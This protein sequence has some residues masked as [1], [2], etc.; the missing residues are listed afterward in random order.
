MIQKVAN[1]EN[2][3]R[4]TTD[5]ESDGKSMSTR[6]YN[7]LSRQKEVFEPVVPGKVGIYCCGPTVYAPSHVGHVVGPVIFDTVKR[8][9]RYRGYD[10]TFVIN[11]TDVDDKIINK[12]AEEKTSTEELAERITADYIEHLGRLGVEVDHFPRATK[13]IPHM[14]A[15]IETLV[16]KGFAYPSGG[17]VYFDVTRHPAY[18]KLSNRNIDEMMAGARKEVSDLKRHPSDFA[19]WKGAKAG[20]PAWES[21]WGPGRPGWHIECSAMSMDLLG[22]TFDI[23]G[24]GLDLCFPHH[25]D[26]IAQSECC[27]GKTYAK[28]WMHNGLMQYG[29]D[30]RKMGG[31]CMAEEGDIASQEAAKMSKSKGNIVTLAKLLSDY[32]PELIRFFLLSTHYRSPISFSDERL[33]EVGALLEKAH[34]FAER[35][36]QV[37]G[38]AFYE[39]KAP[40]TWA[41]APFEAGGSEFLGR[42]VELRNRY[43]EFMDDDFN[44]AGAIGTMA[45]LITLLNRQAG[46]YES[47]KD[48]A[49]KTEFAAGAV[50]LKELADILGILTK[51]P[52]SAGGDDQLTASLLDLLLKVRQMARQEKSFALSDAIRDELAE[53]GVTIKDGKE[54][55]SWKIESSH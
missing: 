55:S 3:E 54:G 17:D 7:T 12:A 53:L 18:G 47:S 33:K 45:E 42:V 19:L 25:E 37:M 50:V 20:E 5:T 39:L 40:Q 49:T 2:A 23:H 13:Y 51:A 36:E 27:T 35:Y 9:L 6:I 4:P 31:R 1:Q 30:T 11:I 21:P 46:S 29:D 43:L 14:L 16:K 28:Y 44:T 10:V 24:G 15:M 48:E 34:T 41:E 26:E 8:F 38:S 52:E 22:E 32:S